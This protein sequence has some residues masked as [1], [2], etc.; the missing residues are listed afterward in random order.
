MTVSQIWQAL[1]LHK[2]FREQWTVIIVGIGMVVMGLMIPRYRIDLSIT[3]VLLDVMGYD[4]LMLWC[5]FLAC[6]GIGL[7][8]RPRFIFLWIAPILFYI[9]AAFSISFTAGVYYLGWIV[10][11][12]GT[13]YGD[14]VPFIKHIKQ[15]QF[16]GVLHLIMGVG[17]LLNPLGS[18][19]DLF[20]NAL[21][22][23]LPG[24]DPIIF[25]Q[26]LY[27]ITGMLLLSPKGYSRAIT[28]LLV[29][30]FPIHGLTFIVVIAGGSKILS[31]AVPM[32]SITLM[33]WTLGVQRES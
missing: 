27:L 2:W 4:R 12:L 18:S 16:A 24:I 7:L 21:D 13:M 26:L 11:P 30:P 17:L 9:A 25:Y 29:S 20:Y 15:H 1:Q 23:I 19:M 31:I 6:C 33:W 10:I 22:N 5:A 3:G 8:I 28:Q 14:H 32:L